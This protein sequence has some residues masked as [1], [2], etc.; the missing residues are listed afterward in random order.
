MIN[1]D[2]DNAALNAQIL[3]EGMFY[4]ELPPVLDYSVL[5]ENIM[6]VLTKIKNEQ[7]TYFRYESG[8][9]KDYRGIVPP[10]Y[11]HGDGVEAITYYAFK[12]DVALREMQ[13]PHLLHYCSFI[14]NS[15]F[16]FEDIFTPLYMD[17]DNEKYVKNSNSHFVIGDIFTIDVGYD[18]CEELEEGVFTTQNNKIQNNA[19]IGENRR[20]Y[21]LQ[22]A[23]YLYSLKM[24]I[25]S[26]FPNMYTHY[27]EKIAEYEPYKE[28]GFGREYFVFLDTF[29]QKINNNQTKGIPA[30]VF[31]SHIA[32]ELC[33]I[34]VDDLIRREI[35]EKDIGYIRYVDDMTFFSDSRQEL[36]QVAIAVQSI[37][38]QFRLRINGSK[39]E[40][41]SNARFQEN[42]ANI[43]YVY[44]RLR[45]LKGDGR[46][47]LKDDEFQS[48]K[49]Y[50]CELLENEKT[51]QMKTILTLFL[52]R[53]REE[54]ID[55][56]EEQYSW[57][58]YIYMLAFE[59]Q[60]LVCHVYKV[61]D[62]I[63]CRVSG[64]ELYIDVLDKKTRHINQRY[65]DTLLQIWHYYVLARHVDSKRRAE[66]MDEYFSMRGANP[67]IACWFVEGEN[68]K[69][70]ELL[71][72]IIKI[73]QEETGEQNWRSQIMFSRWW[74]PLLRMKMM[75]KYN[76]CNFMKSQNFPNILSD[77]ISNG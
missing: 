15:L 48:F 5:K 32:A 64:K 47:Q 52:N 75:D 53:L 40:Y 23:A 44:D 60:N 26:F 42:R 63:L 3:L 59:N 22:Q 35:A 66:Y 1:L 74:L 24:D 33:M 46:Y 39:T 37:L 30:G 58:C 61:L 16:V 7:Y 54:K 72:H 45:F 18:D 65:R 6:D 14:Y 34:C 70:R 41:N 19:M 12:K 62:E 36:E 73:F 76:Y 51:A 57:F 43:S 38:N 27:F 28:L 31:S 20:R 71:N 11:I 67:I 9:I 21:N 29:H 55:I 77:L 4:S 56:D 69:N 2:M 25:E 17:A 49:S 13:I 50:M 10:K 68:N 8:F